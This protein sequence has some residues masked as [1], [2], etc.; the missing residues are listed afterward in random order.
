[1][2]AASCLATI[3]A[4]LLPPVAVVMMQGCGVQLLINLLLCLLGWIPGIIHVSL[5]PLC[6]C[7]AAPPAWPCD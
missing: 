4:L 5:H 1:M 6:T 2:A 3:M 7:M